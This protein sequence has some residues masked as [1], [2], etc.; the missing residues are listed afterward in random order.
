MKQSRKGQKEAVAPAASPFS[1]EVEVGGGHFPRWQVFAA[2]AAV[3]IVIVLLLFASIALWKVPP[4]PA[5]PT[6]EPQPTPTPGKEYS[7]SPLIAEYGVGDVPT[8]VIGC[9]YKVSGTFAR[10]EANG[11]VP[12]GTE[13]RALLNELCTATQLPEFCAGASAAA[14]SKPVA[15]IHHAAC[16]GEGGAVLVYAFH[17]PTCPFC[18]AQWPFLEM[19]SASMPGAIELK[20][21]CTPLTTAEDALCAVSVANGLF[22]E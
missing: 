6:P 20:R 13:H 10:S 17:S 9:S 18:A 12:A 22:S 15:F 7:L 16:E 3:L 2:A 14:P 1:D 21:V 4:A 8:L 5:M 19:L 11:D